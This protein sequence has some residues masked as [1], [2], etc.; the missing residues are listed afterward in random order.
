MIGLS[1][2]MRMRSSPTQ[3]KDLL[4]L[5]NSKYGQDT[6]MR[7]TI[8]VRKTR[9]FYRA[10]QD[11]VS[12]YDAFTS[13]RVEK[14]RSVSIPNNTACNTACNTV[15]NNNSTTHVYSERT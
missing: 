1:M 11:V 15:T 10:L 3:V 2:V 7:N 6:K 14:R 9:K 8:K 5:D 12:R 13:T 4:T